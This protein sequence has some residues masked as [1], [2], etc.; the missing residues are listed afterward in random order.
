[1]YRGHA[2]SAWSLTSPLDR[3]LLLQFR[4]EEGA[5]FIR[6]AQKEKSWFEWHSLEILSRFRTRAD[7]IPG[8]D[9][10][11]SDD[12][13]WALGRHYGLLPPLLDWSESPYVA[14]FFAFEEALRDYEQRFEPP[15][16][17]SPTKT[18]RVWALRVANGMVKPGEFELVSARP[19][20]F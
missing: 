12:E 5:R 2:D 15:P 11:A 13:V 8:Y 14:A 3:K 9:R 7:G 4:D 16:P 1:I 10:D 18:V 20:A 6:G 17:P 19:K